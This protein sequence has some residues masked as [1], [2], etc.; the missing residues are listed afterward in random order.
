L[1]ESPLRL[2]ENVVAKLG[3]VDIFKLG[4]NCM[5]FASI[6]ESVRLSIVAAAFVYLMDYLVVAVF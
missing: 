5:N 6:A 2:H 3:G 4:M 1:N